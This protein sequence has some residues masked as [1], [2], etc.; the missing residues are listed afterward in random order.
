MCRGIRNGFYDGI[1]SCP[2]GSKWHTGILPAAFCQSLF[3]VDHK[4]VPVFSSIVVA[5]GLGTRVEVKLITLPWRSAL[6]T[7]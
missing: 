1:L 4:E 2:M 7:S 5:F 6:G 3:E